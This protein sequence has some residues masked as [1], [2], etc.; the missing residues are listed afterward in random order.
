MA[1]D[2]ILRIVDHYVSL[3]IGDDLNILTTRHSVFGAAE[4]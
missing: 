3:E 4:I 1:S 2:Y